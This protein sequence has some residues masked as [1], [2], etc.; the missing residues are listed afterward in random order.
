MSWGSILFL[1]KILGVGGRCQREVC[2]EHQAVVEFS[3]SFFEPMLSFKIF[4]ST[5]VSF[6]QEYSGHWVGVWCEKL[7]VM[8]Y[9][10]K[11]GGERHGRPKTLIRGSASKYSTLFPETCIYHCF[12]KYRIFWKISQNTDSLSPFL[13]KLLFPFHFQCFAIWRSSGIFHNFLGFLFVKQWLHLT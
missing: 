5:L 1:Q 9:L 12:K 10:F 4:S 6:I 3:F 11:W 2:P 7:G 13:M 8:W